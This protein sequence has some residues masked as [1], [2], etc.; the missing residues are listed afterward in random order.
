M[1]EAIAA[2]RLCDQIIAVLGLSPQ[3]EGEEM[4]VR[5]KGFFGG[6][7]TDLELPETQIKL[8][9][10][11]MALGKPTVLVLL[12]GSALSIRWAQ[13][14][15]PAIV[16]AW[17]P[18]Q[19][20][21]NA[22]ADVIFGNYNPAGRLPVTFY[23][24]VKD[25]PPFEEYAMKGRTYRYFKGTPLYPFGHGLSYTRFDYK[26]V[27]VSKPTVSQRDTIH[28]GIT[29][30]NT[31]DSSGDEV[32]QLYVRQLA[33]SVNEPLKSLKAFARVHLKQGEEKLVRI[34]L[35]IGNLKQYDEVIDDYVVKRGSYEILIGASSSDMR[36]TTKIQVNE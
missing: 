1:S 12:N 35:A 22:V 9:Q 28:V 20:G 26:R 24:S 18:G 11:L 15:V 34:P 2:A 27:D 7:R 8:L 10:S 30:A 32:V 4:S 25:L 16:E 23:N 6:D 14:H 3:L 33:H 19:Q 17:Y 29:I 5:L 13:Q 36:L 21:G 31:G